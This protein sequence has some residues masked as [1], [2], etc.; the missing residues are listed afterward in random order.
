MDNCAHK[1]LP[2]ALTP[3]R[4]VTTRWRAPGTMVAPA[5]IVSTC[6]RN[7]AVL[8]LGL[9]MG[10]S[11][12]EAD[13]HQN[14]PLAVKREAVA[15]AV[16][17][18]GSEPPK[19]F[20]IPTV[21]YARCMLRWPDAADPEQR[22]PAGA[23]ALAD[24]TGVVHLWAR[25]GGDKFLL[26]CDEGGTTV[27]HPFD[28][29]VASTF[30]PLARTPAPPAPRYS[31]PPLTDLTGLS[32]ADL[33]KAG[34]PPRPDPE[35]AAPLY[36]K[37]LE[38]VSA[39]TTF[40][41]AKGI[42]RPDIHFDNIEP[43]PSSRWGGLALNNANTYYREAVTIFQ[44]PSFPGT[45]GFTEAAWWG[46][47]DGNFGTSTPDVV[48]DGVELWTLGGVSGVYPW[49]EYFCS[50]AG[51]PGGSPC[52]PRF[53][54]GSVSAHPGDSFYLWAWVGDSS[55][56]YNPGAGPT[57]NNYGWYYVYNQTQGQGY[58]NS[59]HAPD[60]LFTG[61]TAE[62]IM[63]KNP[64]WPLANYAQYPSSITGWFGAIDDSGT[65]RDFTHDRYI[66]NLLENNSTQLLELNTHSSG[67]NYESF[68][69]LQGQ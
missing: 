68:S 65:W 16:P 7:A 57:V 31:R 22:A 55:G 19:E 27:T 17:Q 2:A 21:P 20:A 54:T 6:I 9:T 24:D 66:D 29:S 5:A 52:D 58:L 3:L 1:N 48:Q 8:L 59:I 50:T 28:L 62:F 12:D 34:Y 38:V 41:A 56:T 45:Q 35:R 30:E 10:C 61:L 53:I 25:P 33:V 39:A 18:A 26:D 42:E 49:I 13:S 47:L 44:I 40:S 69:W 60:A 36:E 64:N 37:W 14:Q 15:S 43:N 63:E 32:Q 23:V 4:V 67:D 51:A 11:S 46:G